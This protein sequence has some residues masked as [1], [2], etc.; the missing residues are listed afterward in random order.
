MISH[1]GKN[2]FFV[3]CGLSFSQFSALKNRFADENLYFCDICVAIFLQSQIL[4]VHMRSHIGEKPYF[5]K[6][7][8]E[9]FAYSSTL[10]I[11]RHTGKKPYSC[12][13]H[14][15]NIFR[16]LNFKTTYESTFWRKNIFL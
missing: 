9:S 12:N 14:G 3:T 7:C 6:A 2:I 5:C 15:I 1:T 16:K 10:K 4:K 8:G 13:I 11:H